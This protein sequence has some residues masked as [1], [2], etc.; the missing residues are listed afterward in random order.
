LATR[1]VGTN[2]DHFSNLQFLSSQKVLSCK[3]SCLRRPNLIHFL[4]EMS[5]F[6]QVNRENARTLSIASGGFLETEIK[7]NGIHDG[8]GY[9]QEFEKYSYKAGTCQLCRNSAA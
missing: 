9:V 6:F 8:N 3:K 4:F 1:A 5:N 7:G 2:T